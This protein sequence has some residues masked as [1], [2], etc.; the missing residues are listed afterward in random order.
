VPLDT[1][2][3]AVVDVPLNDSLTSFRIVAVATGG[4]AM[5]GTGAASIR[6]TR[7]LMVLPGIAPLAR[8]GDRMRPEATVR[9]TTARAMA[10]TVAAR[11]QALERALPPES[12]TLA[13][14]E[15]RVV[16]W[17]VTVPAGVRRITWE[18]AATATGGP[19]DRVR[20]TQQVIDAV[21]V[22]TYQATLARLD[23]PP[24]RTGGAAG[25]RRVGAG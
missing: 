18:I 7:D 4:A 5:F 21:P 20:V 3:E 11:A 14:G 25:R 9:N 1:G 19:A 6:S 23:R 13:A 22:R 24:A 2:G 15:A 8:E 17:D 12:F 10:V 16:G